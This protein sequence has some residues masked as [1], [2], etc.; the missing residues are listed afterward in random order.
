M[1]FGNG[2]L[3]RIGG[4]HR[5][6][7]ELGQGAQ[8]VA[9]FGIEHAL[10]GQ[11]Q[12]IFRVEQHAHRGLDRVG[13]RRRAL[14]WDGSVIEVA[15]VFGFPYLGRNL[16]EDGPALAAAHGVIGAAHQ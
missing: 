7:N 11:Q 15:R 12:R 1:A 2:A 3:A 4:D 9:R 16:D 14:D 5:R 10:P 13:I 6:R 8:P